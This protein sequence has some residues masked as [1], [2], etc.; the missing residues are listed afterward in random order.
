[1]QALPEVLKG[2][3]GQVHPPPCPQPRLEPYRKPRWLPQAVAQQR[4]TMTL[5]QLSNEVRR[6]CR[7]LPDVLL[8][9]P[10]S[11]MPRRMREVIQLSGEMSDY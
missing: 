6:P 3:E 7:N 5:Q 4:P 1:M 9:Q 11:S 8:Y 10:A 2:A